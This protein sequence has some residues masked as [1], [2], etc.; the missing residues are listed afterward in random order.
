MDSESRLYR[1]LV[2]EKNIEQDAFV[3]YTVYFS[4]KY[5]HYLAFPAITI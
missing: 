3:L 4:A 2:N 1:V 5:D